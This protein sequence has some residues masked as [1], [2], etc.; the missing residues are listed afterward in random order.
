[1]RPA[2][3]CGAN[4]L[5]TDTSFGACFGLLSTFLFSLQALSYV[6]ACPILPESGRL[7][8]NTCLNIL[9][10]GTEL[11]GDDRIFYYQ[12]WSGILVES[13][14]TKGLQVVDSELVALLNIASINAKSRL[15]EC[16]K[17]ATRIYGAVTAFLDTNRINHSVLPDMLNLFDDGDIVVL[18]ASIEAMIAIANALSP[19]AVDKN[20]W[21]RLM[22]LTDSEDVR[23]RCA[24]LRTIAAI[25]T[26][27][28]ECAPTQPLRASF[29]NTTAALLKREIRTMKL[30]VLD[31]LR[32]I[33]DEKY[34]VLETQADVFGE[35]LYNTC[36]V[37]DQAQLKDAYK[38]RPIR[39]SPPHMNLFW[40]QALLRQASLA[41]TRTERLA[42][43]SCSVFMLTFCHGWMSRL[44]SYWRAAT[45]RCFGAM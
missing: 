34:M 13:M 32:I 39:R 20:I 7:V 3:E 6:V 41:S 44:M 38:V 5:L 9:Q 23:I 16:R 11:T 14:Q 25:L 19:E 12:I 18:G 30:N 10:S 1:M 27:I 8:M 35:L 26:N 17:A 24:S 42:S 31:D 43:F 2:S 40:G 15:M 22:N 28:R 33:S 45:A 36:D 37:L 21:P 29:R 4:E